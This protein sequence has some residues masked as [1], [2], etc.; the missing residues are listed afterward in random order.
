L[1]A[2]SLPLHFLY[3]AQLVKYVVLLLLIVLGLIPGLFNLH[4]LMR[5]YLGHPG[6]RYE[7]VPSYDD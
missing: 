6:Y 1:T 4:I 2:R 5:A 7:M 3:L